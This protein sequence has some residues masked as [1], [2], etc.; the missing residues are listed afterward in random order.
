MI[1]AGLEASKFFTF[2]SP[3]IVGVIPFTVPVK[4][5]EF[6]LT[7]EPVPVFPIFV[8][9][10]DDIESQIATFPF[11]GASSL[12]AIACVFPMSPTLAIPSLSKTSHPM[13]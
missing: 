6:A 4:V 5:G 9:N 3:T 10:L 7:I 8:I 11:E 13:D 12:V 1:F 2:P